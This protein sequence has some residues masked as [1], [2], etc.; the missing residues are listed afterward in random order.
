M[1]RQTSFGFTN[2]QVNTNVSISPVD[3]KVVTNYA[4]KED[5][6]N[7]VTEENV[8][9]PLDQP[10]VLTFRSRDIPV[11]NSEVTNQYP[12]PVTTGVQYVIQLD[13]LLST[14]D[15]SVGYRVDDPIVAYLTI[16]HPKSGN[17][18][19]SHVQAVVERLIGAC[20]N[21]DGSSRFDALMRSA[22]KPTED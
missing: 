15:D 1:A 21:S 13:E 7:Q 12:A 8:T 11:V 17:V 2:T 4:L 19:S 18:T 3:L 10:E 6:P 16:R 20:Y 5:E 22:L 14:R 9:S